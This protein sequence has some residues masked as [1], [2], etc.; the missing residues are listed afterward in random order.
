MDVQSQSVTK[1]HQR[2][3]VAAIIL[4]LLLGFSFHTS[5]ASEKDDRTHGAMNINSPESILRGIEFTS[6][7][8]LDTGGPDAYGYQW[9][10]TV[11][12]SWKDPTGATPVTFS[13]ADDGFAG[14]INLGLT[15]PFYENTYSQIY[16][17]TN[18]YLSFDSLEGISG[19][20]ANRPIPH[21]FAPNNFIAPFWSDL[22]VGGT[23]N[24]GV[25]STQQGSDGNGSFFAIHFVELS[26]PLS[27]AD[28]LTFQVILYETGDIWFQ[29]QSLNGN[30]TSSVGLEDSDALI[31]L[32]YPNPLQNNLAIEFQ[33][34]AVDARVK[35]LPHFQSKMVQLGVQHFF[36]DIRNTG[37]LGA[38]TFN[39]TTLDEGTGNS[40][41][42]ITLWQE[43]GLQ[44][45][46]DTNGDSV[47]DTGVLAQGETKTILVRLQAPSAN[48]EGD[49]ASFIVTA[50]SSLNPAKTAQSRFQAAIPA[51]HYIA[52]GNS[53]GLDLGK[54]T[55]AEQALFDVTGLGNN[56]SLLSVR[57]R[58]FYVWDDAD[59]NPGTDIEYAVL[60][61]DGSFI[62]PA[63]KLTNNAGATYPT[64]DYSPTLAI[65]PDN[66]VGVVWGRRMFDVTRGFNY[67]IYFAILDMEGNLLV[68]PVNVT[69]NG[70]CDP[71]E[72]NTCWQSGVEIDIPVFTAPTIMATSDNRFLLSWVDSRI[73]LTGDSTDFGYIV[74]DTDGNVL[75][76]AFDD[77]K[78]G[79]AG[80]E[81]FGEPQLI[82]LPNDRLLVT[83]SVFN[84][85]N[86]KT[87]LAYDLYEI[88]PDPD[89]LGNELQIEIHLADAEGRNHD[90]VL[91]AN[92]KILIAWTNAVTNQIEAALLDDDGELVNFNNQFIA[93]Q[94]PDDR[95]GNFVSVAATLEGK[96]VASWVDAEAG[97]RVYYALIAS[98]GAVLTPPTIAWLDDEPIKVSQNGQGIAPMPSPFIP[99]TDS[100]IYMPI[101]RR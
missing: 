33:R 28:L 46:T 100:Q 55:T 91:I 30:L 74:F 1:Q 95:Q 98:T 40:G 96:G 38:D 49:H 84:P 44:G 80:G 53:A 86:Q 22:A 6:S 7:F 58:Y 94:T 67:N 89:L 69:N 54:L 5:L 61:P 10:D 43:D 19:D 37:E 81:L 87:T 3:L 32:P 85:S 2:R 63:T 52:F 24:S 70:P 88:V 42:G 45:L 20:F 82:E 23:F 68:N 48:E 50:A 16:I 72:P 66:R 41:W 73:L 77:L 56:P 14:P 90:S 9:D 26:K 57:D 29:Y 93:L 4:C 17:S 62:H 47:M 64:V 65:S 59:S 13:A 92:S 78:N 8:Y 18:G 31:G 36:L 60:N 97:N 12:F 75:M 35:V 34:P 76:P 21:E 27:P 51:G 25:V 39:L 11:A 99:S 79:F 71:P 83:Y 101:V 15:F